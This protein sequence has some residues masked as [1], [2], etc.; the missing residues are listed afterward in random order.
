MSGRVRTKR[1]APEKLILLDI[2]EKSEDNATFD[3]IIA[4]VDNRA[5]SR[6]AT[7]KVIG[8]IEKTV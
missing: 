8:L 6:G 4:A 1:D 3:R 5:T 2:Q 7:V